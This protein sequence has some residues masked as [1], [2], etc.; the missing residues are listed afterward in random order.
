MNRIITLTTDFGISDPYVAAVKGAILN[1][2]QDAAIVD[3]SHSVKPQAV[4]QAAFHLSCPLPYF[5]RGSIHLVVV[6]P[7]VGTQR[8]GLA[9]STDEGVFVGPDNGSTF[10]CAQVTRNAR[11][12]LTGLASFCFRLASSVH[13]YQSPLPSFA[14][15]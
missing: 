6:D 4:E 7:S 12:A 2:N 15:K 5:R 10:A 3:V 9:L 1:I 14:T 8:R 13:A 11:V